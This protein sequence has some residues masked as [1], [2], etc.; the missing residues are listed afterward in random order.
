MQ[1]IDRHAARAQ[2]TRELFG[3][4]RHCQFRLSIKCEWLIE[5][6]TIE[7]VEQDPLGRRLLDARIAAHNHDPSGTAANR[8]GEAIDEREM[9]D[10]ID[11]K[12]QFDAV[13]CLQGG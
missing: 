5:A 9:R 10:V 7:I 4:K 1:R 11:E 2:T 6:L 8:I 13:A 3:K 12:L